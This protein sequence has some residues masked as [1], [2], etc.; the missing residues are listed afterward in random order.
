MQM[1]PEV[2][3]WQCHILV[4]FFF[5]ACEQRQRGLRF[6]F[7]SEFPKDEIRVFGL[8]LSLSYKFTG[9]CF[10]LLINFDQF[11]ALVVQRTQVWL[12]TDVLYILNY[13]YLANSYFAGFIFSVSSN[14]LWPPSV[15]IC[16]WGTFALSLALR[17]NRSNNL[18]FLLRVTFQ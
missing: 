14:Q 11:H 2:N 1:A 10:Y 9:F 5:P 6:L 8:L 4:M 17:L 13:T 18:F 15:V 12:W 16:P 3:C 7:S